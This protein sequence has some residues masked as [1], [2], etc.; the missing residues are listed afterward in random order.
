MVVLADLAAT[1]T[2]TGGRNIAGL[3]LL[4]ADERKS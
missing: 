2:Q 3:G 1:S 4:L